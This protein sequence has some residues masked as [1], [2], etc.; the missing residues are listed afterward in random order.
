MEIRELEPKLQH[1]VI[2]S[3]AAIPLLSKME[4]P[5][6]DR[7][8]HKARLVDFDEGEILI[9]EEQNAESLFILLTG[10]VTVFVQ[11]KPNQLFG[12]EDEIE[13]IVL[14][15]I[16]APA[17]V[18][19]IAFLLGGKRTASV[20]AKVGVQTLEISR[21]VFFALFEHATGFGLSIAQGIAERVN[22][23]TKQVVAATV[24][25]SEGEHTPRLETV[26]SSLLPF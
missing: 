20:R 25:H 2:E 23:L 13:E 17:A 26:D 22:V 19:E 14:S 16:T 1:F 8:I 11:R 18:G 24:E 21:E 7:L 5:I 12:T 3:L 9:R 10:T 6:L 4:R 15:E